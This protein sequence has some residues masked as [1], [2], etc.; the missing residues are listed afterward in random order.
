MLAQTLAAV[1]HD[2]RLATLEEGAPRRVHLEQRYRRLVETKGAAHPMTLAA[3]AELDGPEPP[4]CMA[5]LLDWSDELFARSGFD[6]HGIAPLTYASVDAWARLTDRTPEPHEV[7][8]LMRLD[9][10]RRHPPA[11]VTD[12]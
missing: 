3:R 7:D 11:E 8:A 1:A 5:Y 10:V 9:S 2:A 6:M 12:G 4:E